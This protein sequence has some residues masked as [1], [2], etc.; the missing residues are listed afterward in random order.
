MVIIIMLLY[1][2]RYQQDSLLGGKSARHYPVG[3]EH[4]DYDIHIHSR[5]VYIV[6]GTFFDIGIPKNNIDIFYLI[7]G[8]CDYSAS[9]F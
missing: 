2:N 8:D 1:E 3:S 9:K 4:H 6:F 5:T 7:V